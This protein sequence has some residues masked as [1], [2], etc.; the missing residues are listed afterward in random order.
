MGFSTAHRTIQNDRRVALPEEFL[1]DLGW[2]VGD[3]IMIH[4]YKGKIVIENYNG[5]IKPLEERI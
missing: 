2:N 1:K 5:T 3:M 4:R